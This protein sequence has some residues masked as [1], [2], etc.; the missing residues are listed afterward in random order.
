MIPAKQRSALSGWLGTL[1]VLLAAGVAQADE[2]DK[3]PVFVVRTAGG[4]DVRG[5]LRELK[6]DW[7]VRLGEEDTTVGGGEVVAL[8][9]VGLPLPPLPADEHVILANGDCIPVRAPRIEGERLH[10]VNADL[11]GGKETSVPLAAI[12]VLWRIAPER[13]EDPERLRRR[14]ATESRTSDVV[15]LR[16]GDQLA[17]VLNG[18]EGDK[19]AIEV[20][21][22]AVS[23]PLA[24]VA[25]VALSTE[26]AEKLQ[27]K[28]VF[29]KLVL[30]GTSGRLSVTAAACKDGATLEATTVFDVRL[31]VPLERV[32]ALDLLG[33]RV[34]YLSDLKY[35]RYEFLPYLDEH[36]AVAADANVSGHDLLLGGSTYGKGLGLH[37]HCRLTYPL[38]GG[39]RRFEAVV[40]LD[41]R[42][43]L[44][45]SVRVRVL[46]DGRPLELGAAGEL[47]ARS[48]PLAVSLPVEGVRELT[49]VV[50]FSRNGNVQDAVNWADARLVR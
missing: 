19:V 8:R 28:G 24:Q 47:T 45:G 33:G 34:A 49:L 22:K 30:T 36:W 5:P 44:E 43:G 27:P 41:D 16:N 10:F 11:N 14:L 26:L 50:E 6:P 15:L 9:R 2:A 1:A 29:G 23:V 38:A 12:A 13:A 32:A 25:A 17:G 40:G 4:K 48:R 20:E 35:A 42:D 39:W 31:K 21:K 18:I 37:S 46:A 7:S 3:P